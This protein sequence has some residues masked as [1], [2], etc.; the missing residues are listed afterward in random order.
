MSSSNFF[1][2]SSCSNPPLFFLLLLP[3]VFALVYLL[4]RPYDSWLTSCRRPALPAESLANNTAANGGGPAPD[5]SLLMGISTVP[6]KYA[7][8]HIIRHAYAL[9]PGPAAARIDIRFVLC[10]LSKEED[11][12]LVALEILR[13]DDIIILNCTENMNDGKTYTYFSS[14]P[15]LF[16]DTPYDYVMKAD[17][18]AYFRLDKLA[19][20]LRNKSREDMYFGLGLPP[21]APRERPPFMAG[22]G[23]VLSWDLV[24]W[25]STSEVIRNDQNGAEDI[26]VGKW[27][28]TANRGVN[29][30]NTYPDMFNYRGRQPE[31]F[32]PGTIAVH[33]LK[34]NE[35]WARTLKHFNVTHGLKHSNLY[36]IP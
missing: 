26:F 36:H 18:D 23:Y 11:Q 30:Y 29:R 9:Q 16:N 21:E 5:F 25:I 35:R 7:R 33:L 27:L 22:M 13:Y 8:R 19:D 14:L 24:Q 34:D 2:T 32:T 1:K 10:A 6:G 17:D 28:N 20:A 4:P 15:H 31:D 12:I 3:A